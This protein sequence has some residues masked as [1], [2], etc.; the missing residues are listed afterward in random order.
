MINDKGQQYRDDLKQIL[1][2]GLVE[3]GNQE[4]ELT[5]EVLFTAYY[6]LGFYYKRY[7]QLDNLFNLFKKYGTF[8]ED[9][10]LSKE[11][12][13]WYYRRI[14]NLKRALLL[15]RQMME[16]VSI[17]VNACPYISFAS[18]VGKLLE[19]DFDN[20]LSAKPLENWKSVD[21]MKKDWEQALDAIRGAMEEYQAIRNGKHYG[22]HYAIEG[23]LLM[24]SPELVHKSMEQVDAELDRAMKS[25]NL[26]IQY[27]NEKE[28]DYYKRYS[29]YC[30]Y[31]QKC[32][33]IRMRMLTQNHNAEMQNKLEEIN[34]SKEKL[35]KKLKRIKQ[36]K[37]N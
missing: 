29:E 19:I 25:L 10:L 1:Q 7:D 16:A 14:G 6:A 12:E 33:M 20:Q 15:D 31:Q 18:T 21:E 30:H 11:V 26:A 13:S 8:F 4:A 36:K 9:D 3:Q 23:R 28:E 24:Y 32:N 5:H 37:S 22:K 2:M 27:E 35:Q 34:L 17:N